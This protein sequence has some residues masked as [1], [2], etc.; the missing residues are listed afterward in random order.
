MEVTITMEV[1]VTIEVKMEVTVLLMVVSVLLMEVSVLLMEASVLL[2][3]ALV[4]LMEVSVLLME[5]S[6]LL[7]ELSVLLMEALVLLMEVSVLL[8]EDSALLMEVPALL[9][10]IACKL[11]PPEISVERD[12]EIV[13]LI[14]IA[15]GACF[16]EKIIARENLDLALRRKMTA[17]L[18]IASTATRQIY[19]QTGEEL[20]VPRAT[21]APLDMET[22]IKIRTVSQ[23]WSVVPTIVKIF[24]AMLEIKMIAAPIQRRK[25]K[26]V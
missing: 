8:M 5:V 25:R 12:K 9:E 17:A 19:C 18:T 4:L 16:V 13:K 23:T 7:M 15:P 10:E 22:V 1:T 6:V 26:E 24:T 2:M 11:V 20:A 21:P 14:K 3:A